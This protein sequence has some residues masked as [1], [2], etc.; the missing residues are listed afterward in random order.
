MEIKR[1]KTYCFSPTG[2]SRS[3]V[4]ALA[5]GIGIEELEE[6]DLT[7]ENLTGEKESR[8]G[9]LTIVGVPVYAGRVAELAVNRLQ[10]LS[11][12]GTPAVAVVLYGNRE[13]DDAL[14]EL[15]DLLTKQGFMV[16]GGC[17]FIGEHSYSTDKLP[18]APGRPD[19]ADLE[20]A[21]AFG[22]KIREKISKAG[23]LTPLKTIPGNF[24]YTDGMADIPFT[25]T[26]DDEICTLCG[27]CESV[28]PDGA[29]S[30]EEKIVLDAAPCILCCAC[31][32]SCPESAISMQIPP[33]LEKVAWLHETCKERK[34]PVLIL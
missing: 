16:V 24:P 12:N 29:I 33:L 19:Q 31:I 25:P 3:S 26:V 20:K 30:Q 7:L 4:A 23:E 2:T 34:E 27:V 11:G 10:P 18:I 14:L 1:I 6:V 21:R 9:D 15:N 5:E 28:C 17:A 32:K 22:K 8:E 13:Y